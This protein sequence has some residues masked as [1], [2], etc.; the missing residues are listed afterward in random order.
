MVLFL[1]G[2]FKPFNTGSGGHYY[3]LLQMATS[4]KRENCIVV[5]GDFYP[6]VYEPGTAALVHSSFQDRMS[7]DIGSAVDL[8]SVSVV[9]SYDMPT[10]M[11]GCK[12]ASVLG[13]P[14][15]HTKAGGPPIKKWSL[16]YAHQ[17]VFHRAD[18]DFFNTRRPLLKPRRL[19]FISNRVCAPLPPAESRPVPLFQQNPD[20]IKII[21]ICRIGETYKSTVMQSIALLQRLRERQVNAVLAIVGKIEEQ[22][23]FSEITSSIAGLDGAQIYTDPHFTAN[24][25]ELVEQADVVVGTGRGFMEGMSHGKVM[26]FPVAG[27]SLPCFATSDNY[28]VAFY[29][30][31]STRIPRSALTDPAILFEEFIAL[32]DAN[33]F[34]GYARFSKQRFHD[35]HF[36]DVGAQKLEQFYAS[37]LS[38]ETPRTY[39]LRQLHEAGLLWMKH[40]RSPL[41]RFVSQHR[42]QCDATGV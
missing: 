22:S 27:E 12:L 28:E 10:S 36:I 4:L 16:S 14:H 17:I 37:G 33:D 24:A 29:H 8:S 6:P 25:S 23:V 21:R 2:C 32:I 34:E 7:A 11:L 9:H 41:L 40:I 26:F 13:V 1:I 18:Y 5:V 38:P 42:R 15:V 20:A 30:N 31:F 19:G 35:D 3:S 39:F